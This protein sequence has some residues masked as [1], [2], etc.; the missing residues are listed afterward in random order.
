MT[1][2]DSLET[3]CCR[4]MVLK[5]READTSSVRALYGVVV[6]LLLWLSYWSTS[7]FL[8][9]VSGCGHGLGIDPLRLDRVARPSTH[10]TD[11]SMLPNPAV[12]TFDRVNVLAYEPLDDLPCNLVLPLNTLSPRSPSYSCFFLSQFV[13][14]TKLLRFIVAADAVNLMHKDIKLE[15]I[16][17][18]NAHNLEL[19][20]L[21]V[22]DFGGA[23]NGIA[24]VS[25]KNRKQTERV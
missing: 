22:G 21:A 20:G 19:A 12:Q 11:F 14:E 24:M 2:V 15:N 25:Q 9:A 23:Q 16:F 13:L 4:S 8:R 18:S 5:F 7:I 3:E 6:V 17:V 10:P 1:S